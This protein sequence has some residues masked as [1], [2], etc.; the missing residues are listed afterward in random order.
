MC[1]CL[2]VYR[3]LTLPCCGAGVFPFRA[4]LI[5]AVN[6]LRTSLGVRDIGKLYDRP[7]LLGASGTVLLAHVM[8]IQDGRPPRGT[9][10]T[11]L[12]PLSQVEHKVCIYARWGIKE[13]VCA[14]V[15]MCVCECS[16]TSGIVICPC[17]H[18]WSN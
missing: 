2:L 18:A 6:S 16:C 9:E 15:C 7:L 13:S 8:D 10:A 11:S 14:D 4:A 5:D 1:I 3:P 17:R 12:V